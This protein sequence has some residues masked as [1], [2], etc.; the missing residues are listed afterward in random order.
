MDKIKVEVCVCTGC[1]MNGAINIIESIESLQ[2][3][4]RQLNNNADDDSEYEVELSTNKCLGAC[5]HPE[6]FPYVIINERPFP[7]ASTENIM[8]AIISHF[9]SSLGGAL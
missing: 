3:L 4:K 9:Q 6:M 8:S 2:D 5:S 7:K 1:V